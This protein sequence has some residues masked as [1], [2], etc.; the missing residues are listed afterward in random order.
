MGTAIQRRQLALLGKTGKYPS[1]YNLTGNEL[2]QP[3]GDTIGKHPGV[4]QPLTVRVDK[5]ASLLGQIGQFKAW[6]DQ[7]ASS[8]ALRQALHQQN[9]ARMTRP[10]AAE[11]VRTPLLKQHAGATTQLVQ[12]TSLGDVLTA[13]DFAGPSG[14]A[15][16]EAYAYDRSKAMFAVAAK[17]LALPGDATRY[18]LVND[19]GFSEDS[20]MPDGYDFHIKYAPRAV[21]RLPYVFERLVNTIAKPGQVAPGLID[22]N[23]TLVVINTEFGRSP[24]V[25]ENGDGRNHHPAA[26][27]VQL[28]GGPPGLCPKGIVGAIDA[29]ANPYKIGVILDGLLLRPVQ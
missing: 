19:S 23:D 20:P 14:S 2:F 4:C 5:G 26:Y 10:G 8:S 6:F 12:A 1:A 24:G 13:Q 9:V 18:V 17:L 21:A 25:Q 11:P 3:F 16:G 22:L 7:A 27:T 15:G 29:N 28:L